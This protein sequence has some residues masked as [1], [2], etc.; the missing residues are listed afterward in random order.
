MLY[1]LLEEERLNGAFLEAENVALQE[2][3][4]RIDERD[5]FLG[6]FIADNNFLRSI[7]EANKE[8]IN[9]T[10]EQQQQMAAV[11]KN[12]NYW[13]E[14]KKTP[15]NL[16]REQKYKEWSAMFQVKTSNGK[17]SNHESKEDNVQEGET[18]GE[19]N[20]GDSKATENVG[21][22]TEADE[23][24]DNVSDLKGAESAGDTKEDDEGVSETK[25]EGVNL[26]A[27]EKMQ[28]SEEISI[29]EEETPLNAVKEPIERKNSGEVNMPD[30]YEE[31]MQDVDIDGITGRY[32]ADI[33]QVKDDIQ[34]EP[35]ASP[36]EKGTV[37][38]KE[39]EK[40]AS[41]VAP[42]EEVQ[43]AMEEE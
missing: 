15:E 5:Q 40:K 42:V 30:S 28:V 12:L 29:A 8:K 22:T 43:V 41:P 1:D 21:E 37:A 38:M 14:L 7:Y 11:Y 24:E 10:D 4:Y 3:F 2:V 16:L 36:V 34:E 33:A 19:D 18:D 27:D 13:E 6:K 39:E 23:E 35:K 26:N 32:L 9:L 31:L 17:S 25:N 20:V